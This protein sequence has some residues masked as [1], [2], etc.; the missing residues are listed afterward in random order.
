M[1]DLKKLLE[2]E[3]INALAKSNKSDLT[4]TEKDSDRII[5]DYQDYIEKANSYFEKCGLE[6]PYLTS[7]VRTYFRGLVDFLSLEH[8]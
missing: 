5:K 4:M 2:T 6:E 3:F 1:T 7:Y 8:D